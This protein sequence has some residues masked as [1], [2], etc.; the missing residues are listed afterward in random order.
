MILR[1]L[2]FVLI[3]SLSVISIPM[4]KAATV[5]LYNE[6]SYDFSTNTRGYLSG[7]DFYFGDHTVSGKFWANNLGQRG[8]QDLDDIGFLPLSEVS[9]P[10]SGYYRFGVLA[11][12]NHTYVSLAQEGEEGNHIVFRVLWLA[13][14]NSNVKIDYHYSQGASPTPTPMSTA[15]QTPT[16]APTVSPSPSPSIMPTP[17]PSSTPSPSP[18]P[19]LEEPPT[20]LL[21]VAVVLGAVVVRLAVAISTPRGK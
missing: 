10:S 4:A 16:A 18:T 19:L 8:L 1:I 7:G 12:V 17:I 3:L 9:I 5:I 20:A 6:D 14:D 15:T 13:T 21:I 2:N 11:V